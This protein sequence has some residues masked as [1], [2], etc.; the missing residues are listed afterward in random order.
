[1]LVGDMNNDMKN[2]NLKALQDN[3]FFKDEL[4]KI[5]YVYHFYRN[6]DYNFDSIESDYIWFSELS[7]FN[8]PFEVIVRDGDFD[9]NNLTKEQFTDFLMCNPLISLADP[10]SNM[11]IIPSEMPKDVVSDLVN[12]F[13]KDLTGPI[14]KIVMDVI[15]EKQKNRFQCFSHDIKNDPLQS[16]LMWSHYSD[17]LRGFVVEFKFDELLD[18]LS[19]KNENYFGGYTLMNY[20]DLGFNDYIKDIVGKNEPLFIDKMLFTKHIDWKYEDEIRVLCSRDKGFYDPSCI[21][22]II[23]G[24]KMPQ[25]RQD[26][27]TSILKGKNLLSKTYIANFDRN[28]FGIILSKY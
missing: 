4:H 7:D 5:S 22:R 25:E 21:S 6:N 23:I 15:D 9:F 19:K 14:N 26:E 24:K 10:D 11:E 13:F 16:R 17:G 27:L 20:T 12:I 8:D 18:S 28:S 1:M 2:S 3:Q